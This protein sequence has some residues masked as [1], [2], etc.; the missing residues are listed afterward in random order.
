GRHKS[1][2]IIRRRHGDYHRQSLHA[3]G[4]YD[5]YAGVAWS[6]AQ[7]LDKPIGAGNFNNIGIERIRSRGA[8]NGNFYFLLVTDTNRGLAGGNRSLSM[9]AQSNQ[10]AGPENVPPVVHGILKLTSLVKV[11]PSNWNEHRAL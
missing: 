9:D 2:R 1:G 3:G 10:E 8:G 4:G 11:L 5:H 7:D 6:L